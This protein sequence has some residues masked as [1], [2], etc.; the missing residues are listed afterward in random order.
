MENI[1]RFTVEHGGGTEKRDPSTAVAET[2]ERGGGGDRET[3][4]D[5]FA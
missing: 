5:R 4:Q 2:E 1:S 3:P